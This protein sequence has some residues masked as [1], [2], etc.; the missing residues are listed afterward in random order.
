MNIKDN[1]LDIYNNYSKYFSTTKFWI[2]LKKYGKVMGHELLYYV[3]LLYYVMVSSE[4]P[5]LHKAIIAGALGYLILPLDFIPDSIPILGFSD[6]MAAVMAVFEKVKGSV[7]PAIE[8]KAR[9]KLDQWFK[10]E[11]TQSNV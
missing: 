6:D 8:R 5:L 2:K 4:T 1:F 9:K 11:P 7:T 3:L 10:N